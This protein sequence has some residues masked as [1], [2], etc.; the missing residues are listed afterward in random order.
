MKRQVVRVVTG[1]NLLIGCLLLQGCGMFG[2][3]G[4]DVPPVEP[5]PVNP[6]EAPVVVSDPA[7]RQPCT[8]PAAPASDCISTT[9]TGL[10][11][12]F[13]LSSAAH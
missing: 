5:I 10:P 8:A 4:G 9:E 12:M 13:L 11:Q 2:K 1:T 6:G 3:K 7:A